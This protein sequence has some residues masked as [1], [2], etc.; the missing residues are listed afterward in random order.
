M[1]M[2][3]WFFSPSTLGFYCS[4][5]HLNLPSDVVEV[6]PEVRQNVMSAQA[7]GKIIQ[8]GTNGQPITVDPPNPT[9]TELAYQTLQSLDQYLPR[10]VEDIIETMG[11]QES[12][13]PQIFQDRL[14]AK[15]AA[16]AIIRE[17]DD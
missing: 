7:S 10:C 16:R 11:I 5:I 4:D 15:R 14:E 6:S 17:D 13:L 9:E 2:G 8:A 3:T 12:T 1:S